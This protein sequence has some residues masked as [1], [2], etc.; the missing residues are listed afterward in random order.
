MNSAG[1]GLVIFLVELVILVAVIAG[2]VLLVQGTR[3]ALPCSMPSA[4]RATSSMAAHVSI[5]L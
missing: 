4:F 5:S 3:K 1:G 2:A